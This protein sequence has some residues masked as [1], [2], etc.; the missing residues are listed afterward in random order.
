MNTDD[1]NTPK[2]GG[3]RTPRAKPTTP[4]AKRAKQAAAAPVAP[5]TLAGLIASPVDII[6]TASANCPVVLMTRI[7]LA[8][9]L[10]RTQFPGWA[11]DARRAEIYQKCAAAI[12]QTAP[13]K[14]NLALDLAVISDAEKQI[15]IE[16][17]L[18]SRE[19]AS[20]RPGAGVVISHGQSLSVM[21][22]EEDHLRI[23]A[24][25]A[26]FQL[27]KVWSQI[28][29]LDTEIES[30]L[31]YAYSPRLGYLT[32][33]PTNLGTA[34]RASA[35]MHLPALVIS[36]NMEKVVRAVNQFGMVV[37][38]LFGEGSDASGSIF[39]IS[40]QTS[41]GESEQ[42]ILRRLQ[43]VLETVIES[44]IN[45]RG[46]LIE[47]DVATLHDKIGRAYGILQNSYLLTTSEALNLLSLMRLAIDLKLFPVE[48]RGQIDR[49]IIETQP[50]HIQNGHEGEISATQRDLLRA[51]HLRAV[52][53]KFPK[54]ET[55]PL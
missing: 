31:D 8:R 13:M 39:Q 43:H 20:A 22:N 34:M 54:P 23:Q 50:G 7:R 55:K 3:K 21:I 37:R 52:F 28:D 45:A 35:M 40:N 15:L 17:H 38:G 19:L 47:T 6:D 51:R 29:T 25:A 32:A 41:L 9:N 24:L 10:A 11:D 27:Q 36:G 18:V 14:N 2:P 53:D 44:E 5:M 26:G 42:E 1:T 30:A 46:K 33:C 48:H 16:R 4:R 12:T 49:L